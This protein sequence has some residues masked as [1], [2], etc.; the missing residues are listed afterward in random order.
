M[1][2][3]ASKG[4]AY[5]ALLIEKADPL[6][7]TYTV[8]V[9]NCRHYISLGIN[10][11]F[12]RSLSIILPF[13]YCICSPIFSNFFI[14]SSFLVQPLLYQSYIFA[15]HPFFE[16]FLSNYFHSRPST[17]FTCLF[18]SMFISMLLLLQIILKKKWFFNVCMFVYL[19][20]VCMW[21]S[22]ISNKDCSRYLRL[23]ERLRSA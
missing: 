23:C 7:S 14:P 1:W 15:S 20:A 10:N 3:C 11:N 16:L 2:Q 5:E 18:V 4:N 22:H 17:L 9:N 13:L 6:F 19:C 21:F 12:W 8:S